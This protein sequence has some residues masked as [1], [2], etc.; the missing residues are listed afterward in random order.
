MKKNLKSVSVKLMNPKKN[1]LIVKVFWF[2]MVILVIIG[3][4]AFLLIPLFSI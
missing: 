3:M 1:K 2:F 4:I